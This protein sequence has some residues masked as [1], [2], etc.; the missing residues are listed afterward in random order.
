MSRMYDYR[1]MTPQER[2]HVVYERRQRGFPWHAPP[3]IRQIS[4][5]YLI[6]AACF[7]HKPIFADPAGLSLLL[8]Q[9]LEALVEAELPGHAWVFLLN[10]YHALLDT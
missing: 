7:E 4:G 1:K 10:H 5:E 8:D 3:H 6:T 9:T 2:Q